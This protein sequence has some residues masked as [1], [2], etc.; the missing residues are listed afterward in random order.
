MPR[1]LFLL[2][3]I[4]A[5]LCPAA[6][7]DWH[8]RPGFP[9]PVVPQDN[10]M[11]EAKV[12]L[13]R[14]LFYD[15]RLSVNRTQSCGTC[16]RQEL[17]FTDGAARSTGATG[18][19][20]PRSAMSLI[21][22]AYAPRFTWAHRDLSSLEEQALVPL[23]GTDP[24]EMGLSGVEARVLSDLRAE[25][26]YQSLF[27]AAFPGEKDPFTLRNLTHAI[28]AFER[29][30][31]ST[32]SPYDRYRYGHEIRAISESAR[33]GEILFFSGEKA[34]C[35]QCHGGWNFS[36]GVRYE[37]GPDTP[38]AFHNTGL[39]NLPGK[40]SYP[41]P[42]TGLYRTSGL[43]ADVGKFKAPTL[44]NIAVTAPYMHDGSIATL[45]EVIGHYAAGG[46]TANPNK[47]T[48]LHPLVLNV[49]DKRD[50]VEFLK[51]LTDT[52]ALTDPRWSNP[53]RDPAGAL[54][55]VPAPNE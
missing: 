2:F 18:Q 17:A 44:R 47:S 49:E 40:F 16:H 27:L 11:S 33:R 34:G 51:S 22:A 4:V 3:A 36:G 19:K 13:G 1:L 20:H 45:E 31:I 9:V 37:G 42:N 6:P 53:W 26:R 21:N 54:H 14:L 55:D 30:L 50:L 28:A 52:E 10:P 24:V 12:E 39:Y 29:T 35:F 7:F 38:M 48:I 8:V 25:A 43:A 41:E 46:R 23:L 15:R 5:F 32:R